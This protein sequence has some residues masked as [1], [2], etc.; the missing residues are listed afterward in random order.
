MQEGLDQH[1]EEYSGVLMMHHPVYDPSRVHRLPGLQAPNDINDIFAGLEDIGEAT[2]PIFDKHLFENIALAF[3][4]PYNDTGAPII[5][6]ALSVELSTSSF[7]LVQCSQANTMVV[8]GTPAMC[9]IATSKP[10]IEFEWEGESYTICLNPHDMTDNRISLN[11][12]YLVNIE[13]MDFPLEY[14]SKDFITAAFYPFGDVIMIEQ[15]SLAGIDF[16]SLSLC[17]NLKEAWL[18]RRVMLNAR[19]VGTIFQIFIKGFINLN[20]N[21]S[22]PNSLPSTPSTNIS[23]PSNDPVP[24][25]HT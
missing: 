15:S 10:P 19:T 18:P 9:P 12:G 21:Q 6:D 2:L 25:T 4:H 20:P 22:P 5:R 14:W 3:I 1:H 17:L 23:T 7:R 11:K 13:I 24:S 16:D 8:F